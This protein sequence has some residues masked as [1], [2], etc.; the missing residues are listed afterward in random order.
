M[1]TTSGSAP[2]SSAI[3]RPIWA[4]SREWV[5][6]VRGTPLISAPSPGPTTCVLP[7]S[8]RSAAECSTRARSRANGLRRPFAGGLRRL[9]FAAG[10]VVCGVAAAPVQPRPEV[11]VSTG[12][13]VIV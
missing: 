1:S 9:G 13:F 8:R 5:S 4:T 11:S 3:A 7:A 12:A 6:R 10:A 2:S